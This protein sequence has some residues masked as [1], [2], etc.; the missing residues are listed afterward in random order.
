MIGHRQHQRGVGRG[1]RIGG[2]ATVADIQIDRIDRA[3]IELRRRAAG[4]ELGTDQRVGGD[5]AARAAGGV[6]GDQAALGELGLSGVARGDVPGLTV[7]RGRGRVL[8]QHGIVV[9]THLALVDRVIAPGM[10]ATDDEMAAAA[11]EIATIGAGD[12][13]LTILHA[14]AVTVGDVALEARET[15][16]ENQVDHASHRIGAV[17]GRS[18]AGHHVDAADQLRRQQVEVDAAFQQV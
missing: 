14:A 2:A 16:V 11:I 17:G 15:L 7:G 4:Q 10:V 6:A 18:A 9:P 1:L 12:L 5:G 3:E 13:D 8:H